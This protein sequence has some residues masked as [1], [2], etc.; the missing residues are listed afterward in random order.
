VHD[1]LQSTRFNAFEFAPPS[2]GNNFR[3]TDEGWLNKHVKRANA[4]KK[5]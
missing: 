5:E 4:A 1:A 2:V 3:Y